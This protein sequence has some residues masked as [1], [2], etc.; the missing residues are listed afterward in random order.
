MLVAMAATRAQPVA[1]GTAEH[2]ALLAYS[3]AM[4]GHKAEALAAVGKLA[5]CPPGDAALAARDGGWSGTP[6]YAALVRFGLWD[7]LLALSPPDAHALGLTAGYLYARGVALAAR[8]RLAEARA[9]LGALQALGAGLPE[10]QR[11]VRAVVSVAEPIVAARIAA[12]EGRSDEAAALL[13]RAVAAEDQLPYNEPADWFFPVRHLLGAQLLIA[14]RAAEAARIYGEDLA[15]NP[16]NG[17]SLDGLAAALRAQGRAEAA[18]RVSAQS[19]AAWRNADVWP[20]AS[21]YWIAGPDT[22]SCECQQPPSSQRQAGGEL[23]G[24]QHEAGVH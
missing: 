18:A 15:R 2:Y 7:E 6:Q 4:A 24:A 17:W 22:R 10:S 12:S 8:G 21:A 19:A 16:A 9:D 13:N 23:L 3:A 11:L 20:H 5:Q 1:S 14:G